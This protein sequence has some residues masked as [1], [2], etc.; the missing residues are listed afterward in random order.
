MR[1]V[2]LPFRQ[3]PRITSIKPSDILPISTLADDGTTPLTVSIAYSDVTKQTDARIQGIVNQMTDE[4][5]SKDQAIQTVTETLAQ[6]LAAAALMETEVQGKADKSAVGSPRGIA[7]LDE[8]GLIPI[9]RLPGV[10]APFQEFDSYEDLPASGSSGIIYGL[11]NGQIFRWGGSRYF[12]ISP[13]PGSTDSVPEGLI[14]LYYTDQRARAA[15]PIQ[16][17]N[18]HTGPAVLLT[19]TDIGLGNVQNLAPLDMPVSTA[20][21]EALSNKAA[22]AHMHSPAEITGLP[23]AMLA[24]VDKSSLG[25]AGG[26]ATLDANGT[27]PASQLPSFVDD[28][29]EF[30]AL[31]TFPTSGA[32]GKIYVALDTGKIYRWSGSTYIEISGSPGSTDSVPEGSANRYFSDARARS[33]VVADI[34]S[35]VSGEANARNAALVAEVS[36]RDQAINAARSAE[37]TARAT[38]ISTA[39]SAES[40]ARATAITNAISTE[41]AARDAAIAAAVAA[42]VGAIPR[43]TLLGQVNVTETAAVVLALGPRQKTFALTGAIVGERYQPFIRQYRLNNGVLTLGRPADYWMIEASCQ[44]AGQITVTYNAPGLAIGGKYELLTDIVKIGV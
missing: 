13:D 18:G 31:S 34:A 32:N 44:V 25:I 9:A 3:R 5:V 29:L 33:A 15:A 37:A 12:E 19:P 8:N 16:S 26:V 20:T 39:V 43:N 1:E 22:I 30:T 2:K 40:S 42:A 36:A 35:A 4:F 24:K 6:T 27:I 21:Q 28:V 10:Q 38:A 14:N 41:V 11:P 23:D 7:E 17:V